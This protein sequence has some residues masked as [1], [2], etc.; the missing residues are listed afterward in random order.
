VR[1]IGCLAG[2]SSTSHLQIKNPLDHWSLKPSRHV[3]APAIERDPECTITHHF[4]Y[5]K[6]KKIPTF[7]PHHDIPYPPLRNGGEGDRSKGE[8]GSG[9]LPNV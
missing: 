6:A 8:E 3:K 1:H 9:G 5:S 4:F 7:A 2:L